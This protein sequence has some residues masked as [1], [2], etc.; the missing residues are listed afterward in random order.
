MVANASHNSTA[1]ENV[2]IQLVRME[3]GASDD[4]YR[5]VIA[6]LTKELRPPEE[7]RPLGSDKWFV[8]RGLS[9]YQLMLI[10]AAVD[11][12]RVSG[13]VTSQ[14]VKK[15]ETVFAL[16]QKNAPLP[17]F[18]EKYRKKNPLVYISL[19][20]VHERLQLSYGEHPAHTVIESINNLPVRD[21]N[22]DNAPDLRCL[23]SIGW[24]DLIAVGA[25]KDVTALDSA[26]PSGLCD[27]RVSQEDLD[28][29]R[30][31]APSS[32]HGDLRPA[33]G[34]PLFARSFTIAGIVNDVFVNNELPD[35]LNISGTI[36]EAHIEVCAKSGSEKKIT[37][38]C[39]TDDA[40]SLSISPFTFKGYEDFV[41]KVRNSDGSG[42]DVS[43]LLRWYFNKLPV[44]MGACTLSCKLHLLSEVNAPED[45]DESP[46]DIK[47]ACIGAQ[48]PR[49]LDDNSD[50]F[51]S[52]SIMLKRM[53]WLANRALHNR[54]LFPML[55]DIGLHIKH[56]S[57]HIA[58][59]L[60]AG[61]G[62]LD[63]TIRLLVQQEAEMVTAGLAQRFH[64]D[65]YD[66]FS[67]ASNGVLEYAGGI[68][69]ILLAFW[70][71]QWVVLRKVVG[72]DEGE[73][74]EL[75]DTM[76]A[77][78]W[79]VHKNSP[80]AGHTIGNEKAFVLPSELIFDLPRTFWYV[81]HEI[82]HQ[83]WLKTFVDG[84][85]VSKHF[86][87]GTFEEFISDM[88]TNEQIECALTDNEDWQNETISW[89]F[90]TQ[91]LIEEVFCDGFAFWGL[92]LS[93]DNFETVLRELAKDIVIESPNTAQS[94]IA[95]EP[96]VSPH[97]Y[98]IW[99]LKRC[100]DITETYRSDHPQ[101][102][103][104]SLADAAANHKFENFNVAE[105][106]ALE[107]I[108]DQWMD[109]AEKLSSLYGFTDEQHREWL[110][111]WQQTYE[112]ARDYGW[113]EQDVLSA[114]KGVLAQM[115]EAYSSR[116]S[117][118][119][120]HDNEEAVS[121]VHDA[122]FDF[123]SIHSN[124]LNGNPSPGDMGECWPLIEK[125]SDAA[126]R[127]IGST[128]WEQ[129]TTPIGSAEG[130]EDIQLPTPAK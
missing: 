29:Y 109:C 117:F 57:K 21:T 26:L 54:V 76:P 56:F 104:V 53:Y 96:W 87:L 17:L 6:E 116:L 112:N 77:S 67:D 5:N 25:G 110:P 81:G 60:Q 15:I 92:L 73:T 47:L 75:C 107:C 11:F 90:D 63:D 124:N 113:F 62:T 44:E 100:Y 31:V 64:G 129:L 35:D 28:G 61:H 99:A 86:A 80:A 43:N 34:Q 23:R 7:L 36:P 32:A 89:K 19:C 13:T 121:R 103:N 9:N 3:P 18:D 49:G 82:G 68:Q 72:L 111:M 8:L 52:F 125:L 51:R 95:D 27:T 88:K 114:C 12:G 22:P 130:D 83:V 1:W 127:E 74:G 50:D 85:S 59:E 79:L 93:N 118:L 58:K 65:Y 123:C 37:D 20:K 2:V 102:D 55:I 122:M 119:P 84:V 98:R 101:F 94:T 70:Y 97:C 105:E 46:D 45:A 40:Y 78:F 126:L 39:K 42:V 91:T 30:D 108:H 115:L 38:A 120:M 41:L 71:I 128:V 4:A 106:T 33:A 16:Q 48:F 24:A 10:T 66:L 14:H 69:R